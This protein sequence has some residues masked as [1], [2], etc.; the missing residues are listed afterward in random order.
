VKGTRGSGGIESQAAE[1]SG[2]SHLQI[3]S[4]EVGRLIEGVHE[5][6]CQ[7]KVSPP[8]GRLNVIGHSLWVKIA[9]FVLFASDDA[10]TRVTLHTKPTRHRFQRLRVSSVVK[11]PPL[12]IESR[13]QNLTNAEGP[14]GSRADVFL[15]G[16]HQCKP[17]FRRGQG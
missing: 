15:I 7:Q 5:G 1:Y 12:N 10:S 17:N 2:G 6:C 16:A 13:E 9:I 4:I 11:K 14:V 8:C 3:D